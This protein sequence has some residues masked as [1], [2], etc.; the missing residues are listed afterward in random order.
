[1]VPSAVGGLAAA[2]A[3]FALRT[4]RSRPESGSS[5]RG[6]SRRQLLQYG[7]GIAAAAATAGIAGRTI[8]QHTASAAASRLGV[9]IP[10]PHS[11]APAIAGDPQADA[12]GAA[13]FYTPNATFY[14]VD[15]AL[16]VPQVEADTWSLTIHGM[17]DQPLHITYAQLLAM[18]LVERDITLACVSNDIGG[19]YVG[20]ARWTGVLLKPLLEKAG[21]Q[22]GSTQILSRSADGW[23]CGTPTAVVLDG[24]DAMLA[25]SMN[26]EPLP[27]KHGFPV[28]MIVPGLYGYA[29]ATKWVTDIELTTF[30]RKAYWVSRGYAQLGPIKTQSRIDTPKPLA[31]VPAGLVKV[32]GIA[33][34]QHKGVAKVEISIDDGPWQPADLAGEDTVDTWRQWVFPWQATA[35]SHRITVRATDKT[36]YVQTATRKS[37]YP[38]GATG[39]QQLLVTVA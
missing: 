1:M 24:R 9:K 37:T 20:N 29:S 13:S 30:E 23:T 28:R 35:G 3:L 17:V 16:T 6:I 38:D 11:K 33:W 31:T 39:Q 5:E 22:P 36:G 4:K 15:T 27:L 21:V 2:A 26:G 32:A 19:P 10:L 14:R 34:A 18:P 7:A 12:P 25:V 8:L